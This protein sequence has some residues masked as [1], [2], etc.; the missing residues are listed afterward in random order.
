MDEKKA[1]RDA[2]YLMAMSARTA[3]KSK[4]QDFVKIEK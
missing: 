3:P 4:G 1:L 2:A